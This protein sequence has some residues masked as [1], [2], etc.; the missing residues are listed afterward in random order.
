MG[1]V[2]PRRGLLWFVSSGTSTMPAMWPMAEACRWTMERDERGR[3]RQSAQIVRRAGQ[4]RTVEP[5][6]YTTTAV[7][8]R[9]STTAA[10]KHT[11][12]STGTRSDSTVIV[13]WDRHCGQR[14]RA[15]WRSLQTRIALRREQRQG[16]EQE[17]AKARIV[18][19]RAVRRKFWTAKR[20]WSMRSRA[21]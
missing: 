13:F 5:L 7:V 12:E 6:Y 17:G 11:L 21:R 16:V 3:Q 18:R 2:H 20:P 4:H 10:H 19:C 9:H 1:T 14:R 15:A 8:D